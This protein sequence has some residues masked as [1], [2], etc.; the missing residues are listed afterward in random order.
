VLS[1]LPAAWRQAVGLWS[2]LNARKKTVVDGV[3]LPS[4]NDE[5]L[6]YQT[7]VGAWPNEREGQGDEPTAT[8]ASAAE[9][10]L[11]VFRER[12]AQYMEKATREAKVYTSWINPNEAYDAAMRRFV[13]GILDPRR[14]KRFLDSLASFSRTVAFFGRFNS[15]AQT[16]VRLAAP[17]VPD[18]YQ[19]TELWDLSLVDPDNRRPVDYAL[20]RRLLGELRERAAADLPALAD[21]LLAQAED[22]RIKLHVVQ[23]ALSLR[24][25]APELFA[26]G[27]YLPLAAAGTRAEHVLAFARRHNAEE[28]VI[29]APRLCVGLADGAE[30]APVDAIW[31]ETLLPLPHAAP[32]TRY[33][34]LL[35]GAEHR[36]D[37]DGTLRMAALLERFPVALLRPV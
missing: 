29:V 15:L 33:R 32:G 2:R 34:D 25:D 7:L 27:A 10:T 5:Y 14:S 19:G 21:E 28:C 17:G 3:P 13:T 35:T 36:V 11:A 16:L 24:R 31:G 30:L 26:A 6:L 4:R 9:E 8:V 12:I 18:L 23:T 20:R 22:G 37:E 1:E